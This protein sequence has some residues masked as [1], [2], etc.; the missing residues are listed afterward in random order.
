MKSRL[1][2]VS[3]FLC[4][5]IQVYA[6]YT[7]DALR[8]AQSG[9]G[10]SA[11]SISMGNAMT[12]VSE[13][14]DA[15]YFNPAGL[16]QSHESEFTSGLNFLG[17]SDNA[18]YLGNNNTL[19]SSQTDLSNLGVI[20]AFPTVRGSF[21]IA[22]GYNRAQD[23]NSA[24]SVS[25]TNSKS[26]IVPSLY[27]PGDTLADIAY[28][29][30]LEDGSQNPLVTK[31]VQ[32]SGKT[33][34]SGGL[35]NWSAS[36]GLDIA[37]N[38]S[39]GVT[40]NLIGGSYQYTRTFI[41]NA[42]SQG[43][44]YNGSDFSSLVLTSQDNQDI[45]G[46]NA[47]VG[48]LYRLE[49]ESGNTIARFGMSIASPTFFTVTYS[50]SSSGVGYYSTPP[51]PLS[52]STS[53]GYGEL[54]GG[55]PALQYDVTTPFKFEVGASGSLSRL[56]LAADIEYVDWTEMQF[57]NSNLPA[58]D[59]TISE[60]NAQIKQ[61]FQA[62]VNLRGGIEYALADP[63][64]ATFVPY[65]RIGGQYLP[66]PQSGATSGMAQKYLSGGIGAKIQNSISL[67]FAYQYGWWNTS[68]LVYPSTTINNVVYASQSTSNEKITNT[69]FMFTFKYDF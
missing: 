32:Q 58:G 16:A 59:N 48:F 47:K 39:V 28:M 38:F 14:F 23:F 50:Y 15:T 10:V 69:N 31:N 42:T 63:D 1:A 53:N 44:N 49:G 9:Y 7:D 35:N 56:L 24:L 13:G 65:L 3:I 36:A 51:S 26:S 21:V 25:G 54:E 29:L 22:L 45:S 60:L 33:Y 68:T 19:S 17:Y 2:F 11:R 57:S 40:L 64:Y 46:V 20:Y 18:T 52:Y 12:G 4:A 55:G 66:S 8:L 5:S 37:N 62:T 41:E 30:Y 61:E 34:T 67:D 43:G 27:Y 6:Q